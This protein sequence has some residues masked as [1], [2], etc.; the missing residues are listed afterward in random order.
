[1]A[2]IVSTEKEL[3]EAIKREEDTI[4]ITGN[5]VKT[6]V[7]IR[8]TGKIAWAIATAAIG[9]AVYGVLAA[10]A[11]SGRSAIASGII[12]PAAVGILGVAATYS[13]ITIAIAAGGVGS[14]T[15]LRRY[16]EISRTSSTVVLKH[17]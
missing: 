6:T 9:I 1:M 15:T 8:A 3:G 4:E 7:R 10:P 12:T 13:A 11:T 16:K 2:A 17:R 14:L 5:L